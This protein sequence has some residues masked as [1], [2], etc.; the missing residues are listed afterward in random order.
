[1]NFTLHLDQ[2]LSPCST[3]YIPTRIHWPHLLELV[4][5]GT[6]FDTQLST[7]GGLFENLMELNNWIERQRDLGPLDFYAPRSEGI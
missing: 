4:V 5:L 6:I 1:M 3:S 7:G 2:I